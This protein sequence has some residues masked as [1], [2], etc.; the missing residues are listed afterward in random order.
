MDTSIFFFVHFKI[1]NLAIYH[2]NIGIM[3]PT[4]KSDRMMPTL[5]TLCVFEL[6]FR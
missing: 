6:G 5:G 2:S 4:K 1:T 3:A